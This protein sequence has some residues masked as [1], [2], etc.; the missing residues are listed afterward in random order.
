MKIEKIP[1]WDNT[2]DIKLTKDG[3]TL[4]ILFSRVLDLYMIMEDGKRIPSRTS[5]IIDFDINTSD[6]EVYKIF[7]KL[8]N[9]VIEGNIFERKAKNGFIDSSLICGYNLLVD[10]NKNITWVSDDGMFEEEDRMQISKLY[11]S[12]CLTFIRNDKPLDSGFKSPTGIYVRLR[13]SGSRY[14]Y[15]Y[16]PFMRMYQTL[17]KVDEKYAVN[18]VKIRIEK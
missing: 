1:N 11:D 6:N 13:T 18:P 7:D 16:I 15:F 10:E 8:Y 17:Q 5:K 14:D 12:Y 9:D 3:K 2:Y 4:T